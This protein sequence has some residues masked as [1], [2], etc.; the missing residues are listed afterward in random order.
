MRDVSPQKILGENFL[1]FRVGLIDIVLFEY[2][3]IV[4][5]LMLVRMYDILI[6]L[7]KLMIRF[8]SFWSES[9]VA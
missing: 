2:Y 4:F 9:V 7:V 8:V 1:R 5:N 6:I 3:L